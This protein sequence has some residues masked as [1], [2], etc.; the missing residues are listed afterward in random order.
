[1]TVNAMCIAPRDESV[2]VLI[3]GDLTECGLFYWDPRVA[4]MSA[5][6]LNGWVCTDPD[7]LDAADDDFAGWMAL[8]G[9]LSRSI[10]DRARHRPPLT[11]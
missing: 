2:V 7:V 4:E 6:A 1:M 5:N 11:R 3:Y 8:P 9:S 10:L